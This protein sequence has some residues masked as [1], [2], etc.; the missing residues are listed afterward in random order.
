MGILQK[1]WG[2]W[3]L[4]LVLLASGCV[5]SSEWIREQG[6]RGASV[7]DGVI[8]EPWGE[9]DGEEVVRY[10]LD[11]GSMKVRIINYGATVTECLVPSA[12]GGE[13]VDVVLGFDDLDGYREK[14]PYFGCIVGRCANR[15]AAGKFELNDSS[16][17]LATNNGPHHL[18][19]GNRGFDKRI[20][21]SKPIQSNRGPGVELRLVSEPGDQG[22]PGEVR[23]A[24]RYILT[25]ANQL[26]VEMAAESSMETPV[27]LAH[28]SY[29]NLAGHESGSTLDQELLLRCSRY[30]PAQDLIP[31]GEVAPVAGTPLDFTTS[32]AIGSQMDQLP[33]PGEPFYAGGYDHNFVVDGEE[34][35]LREVAVARSGKTGIVM[36]V[37]ADQPGLQF[38]SG[39]FLD[40]AGGKGGASYPQY[41]G[42]CLESQIWPDAINRR[43][44]AGWPNV[45]LKPRELYTHTMSHNFSIE[46]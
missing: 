35:A 43:D 29:W 46:E 21:E 27:N 3:L 17:T 1:Q 36:T 30:T 13:L 37:F 14:S 24:V 22:Y 44:V 40:I 15:I 28:H 4:A 33:K 45:V 16:Y 31:T 7:V 20:W 39:N 26:R 12:A 5:G 11:N 34:G 6:E 10:T 8:V 25:G 18:H 19:G 9:I 23:A 32:R 42:F 38:Y 2:V 41:S